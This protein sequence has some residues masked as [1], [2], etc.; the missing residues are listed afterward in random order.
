MP[1]VTSEHHRER[2]LRCRQRRAKARRAAAAGEQRCRGIHR[3]EPRRHVRGQH[4]GDQLHDERGDEQAQ[5]TADRFQQEGFGQQL[6]NERPAA[7]AE[8]RANRHLA[9]ARRTAREQEV[10][11]VDADDQ[12]HERRHADEQLER[13]FRALAQR[14]PAELSG[15]QLDAP[16]AKLLQ[17]SGRQLRLGQHRR[18]D[19]VQNAPV[20]TIELR[21]RLR[22]RD[23][24]RQPPDTYSQ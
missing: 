8:R 13:P 14:A 6:T 15:R 17:R 1:N 12:Q 7:P 22:Q 2:D 16:L 23:V 4:L 24:G 9:G 20:E 21:V 19:V 3:H 5:R 11:D 10:R 18:F